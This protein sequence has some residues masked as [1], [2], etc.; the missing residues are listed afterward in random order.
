[1][2][3][4]SILR[5]FRRRF[6]GK[7]KKGECMSNLIKK[8]LF[9]LAVTITTSLFADNQTPTVDV[10][11]SDEELPFRVS[12]ELADFALP[13]GFQSGVVASCK[14]KWVLL[15]GLTSGLHGFKAPNTTVYVVDPIKGKVYSRSLASRESGLSQDEI[16]SLSM[17]SPQFYQTENTLYIS[18]GY[19]FRHSIQDF[20]TFNTL[21]A[22]NIPN[23]IKWVM[24]KECGHHMPCGTIRQIYDPVFKVT[25]GAMIQVNKKEPT[26]LIFGQDFEGAFPIVDGKFSQSYPKQISRFYIKDDGISLGIELLEPLPAVPEPSFRR[27]DINA[28]PV[29]GKQSGKL[30]LGLA[31]LAAGFTET[32]GTWTVPISIAA[33]GTAFEPNPQDPNTF[34]QGMNTYICPKLGMYSRKSGEMFNVLFGGITFGFFTGPNLDTF[35]TDSNFPFTNQVT[36]IRVDKAGLF[37]QFFMKGQEYPS[38][39]STGQNPGNPLLFGTGAFFI[40]SFTTPKI[41]IPR[42]VDFDKLK[43]PTVVGYIIGGIQSTLPQTTNPGD[44]SASPYIF[45]VTVIPVSNP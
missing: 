43:K 13:V 26:L 14:G 41:A 42:I 18:G 37:E 22:I 10:P 44:S 34:K 21:S 6:R 45:K 39:L 2:V 23:L 33:N 3:S 27:R 9:L 38:I 17:S 12:I 28:I 36:T 8:G 11:S 16:D 35:V 31:V 32:N 5:F 24:S 29:L 1:M 25:A 4:D 40:H 30:R 20:T 19:G 15:C 7:I